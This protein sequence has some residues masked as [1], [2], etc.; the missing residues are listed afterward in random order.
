[1][2][3]KSRPDSSEF[4][5]E[6]IQQELM[7]NDEKIDWDFIENSL[8]TVLKKE[9]ETFALPD[10]DASYR[11]LT[12]AA[13]RKGIWTE[14]RKTAAKA[15][16]P[17]K[18]AVILA[19]CLA[20]ILAVGTYAD[21]AGRVAKHP[22]AH[23]C[24]VEFKDLSQDNYF[25]TERQTDSPLYQELEI[26]GV[27]EAVLPGTGLLN[28]YASSVEANK[29]GANPS[30]TV[31]Y[32]KGDRYVDYTIYS[33]ENTGDINIMWNIRYTRKEEFESNGIDFIQNIEEK[34][35]ASFVSA[36]FRV[37]SNIFKVKT[38]L[39]WD[40]TRALLLSLH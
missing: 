13:R 12:A 16:R 6:R 40:E 11:E 29:C 4:L 27:K 15:K 18:R 31:H 17:V 25:E 22:Q 39:S 38:N 21:I 32:A 36:Y 14:S 10:V 30:V 26:L 5:L 3:K 19:A 23:V 20:V 37:N 24:A 28:E 2:S 1:M 7:K 8:D 33:M 34:D 35:G 9:D